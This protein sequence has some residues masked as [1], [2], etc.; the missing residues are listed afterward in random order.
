MW[1]FELCADDKDPLLAVEAHL[2]QV[3]YYQLQQLPS[4]FIGGYVGYVSYDCIKYYEPTVNVP[5]ADTLGLPESVLMNCNSV[6]VFDHA[7]HVMRVISHLQLD[8]KNVSKALVEKAYAKACAKIDSLVERLESNE[9]HYPP[10][11]SPR[12]TPGSPA[13]SRVSE[14]EKYK[15]FVESLK[16][17]INKGDIIQA[18]PSRRVE[19]DAR[20]SAFEVYRHLRVINPSPYMFYFDLGDFSLVGASPELL[21]RVDGGIVTTHPIAGTRR[22]GKN[23]EEDAKLAQELRNDDKEKAEHVMLVD[24][25]RNDVGRVS[26]PGSVKVESYMEVEMYSHVMHLVS[27][28]SG[29]LDK[30]K[31]A[32]DAFRSIFPAGTV[33]GAPKVRAMQL[34]SDLEKNRRGVYAGAVGYFSLNK[35]LDTCIAIRTIV[36]KGGKFYLQA[37]GGIVHDSDPAAEYQETVNK[38]GALHRAIESAESMPFHQAE[39]SNG[40]SGL[41][42][43]VRKHHL[44]SDW[45][46][47]EESPARKLQKIGTEVTQLPQ[48]FGKF[49]GQYVPEILM[50]ALDELEQIYLDALKDPEFH[51]ELRQLHS[52]YVGRPT[53]L[54][55]AKRLTEHCGGARIWFKR[56]DLCHTGAHK[57]NNAL[58]Q[59]LLAKRTG[60]TRIIAETGAGQHGVA[61][62]TAC[63]LLNLDCTVYMGEEDIHRQALNVFRMKLLG[64]KV[65]P[66]TSGS[67]TL[68]DAINEAMRDWVTNVRT[69]FYL[70]GSAVGPHPFPTIVR[71]F[72]RI[73]GDETRQQLLDMKGKLPDVVMACV[74][75]GSNSIG[76]FH[77]FIEDSGVKIVGVEAAGHGISSGK[78]SATIVGGKPGVLHGSRTYLLQDN[79]GQITETHSISAGLDYPGVGPQHAHLHESGRA[80]YV[81]VTDGEA[82]EGLKAL[83]KLEGIIPALETAHAIFHAMRMAKEMPMDADICVCL[84]GR[85]DKDMVRVAEELKFQLK[86]HD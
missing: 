13:K 62:A 77:P 16:H 84:S 32:Y 71:D 12:K 21:V 72:Q 50:T 2:G 74:G 7:Q 49:G 1:L 58:G 53:P 68:K 51:Q 9:L 37:G 15:G 85:G 22:R 38:L 65:E 10:P 56:E 29:K 69:T 52:H 86:H 36:S 48:N 63:A 81:P 73:I 14:E 44:I 24:L 54:Y 30:S 34:I 75:G 79:A 66:V 33:S 26:E 61:T 31:T 28:V 5:S 35:M 82:L 27:K 18:V 70:L 8:I 76:M 25:G 78:H 20:V 47:E 39:G 42:G 67:K 59:A 41:S 43:K 11:K 46:E 60:K 23:R 19:V 40:K 3:N 55:F 6:V 45:E 80:Q 17:N 83:S 57:I 64:A 4:S